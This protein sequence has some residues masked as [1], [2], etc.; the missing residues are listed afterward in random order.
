LPLQPFSA[1]ERIETLPVMAY[2]TRIRIEC[3]RQEDW[4]GSD[5]LDFYVDS[6]YL[7]RVTIDSGE[8]RDVDGSTMLFQHGFVE[9]G[10][11]ITVYED[12][13]DWDD[14]VLSHPVTDDEIH[15]G[16]HTANTAGRCSYTFSFE[17]E[18]A[19]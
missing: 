9:P 16:L 14:L 17:F 10:Q 15:H 5:E 13:F 3:V 1:P 11:T 6:T 19:I 7:G 2:I 12:D 18:P 4:V 8:T